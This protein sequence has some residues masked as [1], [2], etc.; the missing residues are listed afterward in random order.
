[1]PIDKSPSGLSALR[2]QIVQSRLDLREFRSMRKMFIEEYVGKHYGRQTGTSRK[3]N[4]RNMMEQAATLYTMFLAGGI[5]QV[6]VKSRTPGRSIWA[7]KVQALM[8]QRIREVGLTE[9]LQKLVLEAYFS[10]GIAKVGW[11]FAGNV[12]RLIDDKLVLEPF[13]EVIRLDDWVQDMRVSSF[14]QAEFKGD[15]YRMPWDMFKE[16]RKRKFY[17]KAAYDI[18][19]TERLESLNE[20]GEERVLSLSVNGVSHRSRY[21]P[22][23]YLWDLW[24]ADEQ[25]VITIA[26]EGPDAILAETDSDSPEGGPYYQLGYSDVPDNSMPL[27]PASQLFD[28]QIAINQVMRKLIDQAVNQ[29]TVIAYRGGAE[30]DAEN[31]KNAADGD[32]IRMD[33]PSAVA[34]TRMPGVDNPTQGFALFAEDRFDRQAGN[35]SSL[36]GLSSGA[37]TLGQEQILASQASQRVHFMQQRTNLFVERILRDA[38]DRWWKNPH[39]TFRGRR[40]VD[41]E[42]FAIEMT[43]EDRETYTLQDFSINVEPFSMVYQGPGERLNFLLQ[44]MQTIILPSMPLIM[45]DGGRLRMDKFLEL[46]AEYRNMPELADI[47]EFGPPRSAEA[48]GDSA[49][50]SP[51]TTRREERISKPGAS[52]GGNDRIMQQILGG[53]NPQSSERSALLRPSA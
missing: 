46:V 23:V 40:T 50:Q 8:N 41:G 13:I 2:E 22:Y 37:P 27:P 47:V 6:L 25:K 30:H 36:G 35:L 33:D 51:V 49:R 7:S 45:Q 42:T 1:M 20:D 3:P 10:V 32:L 11:D 39:D 12:D 17:S 24:L 43:P 34:A 48:G 26:D 19:P 14:D 31:I 53:G 21:R 9:I 28:L 52:A 18:T 4:P 44:M 38:G 5:P 16:L 29:K 15:R